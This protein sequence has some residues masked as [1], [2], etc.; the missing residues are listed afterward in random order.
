MAGEVIAVGDGVKGWKTGD[1]V[2]ANFML[3]KLHDEQNAE[4]GATALGGATH[5]VLTEYRTFPAHVRWTSL[6]LKA[7]NCLTA[8]P[9]CCP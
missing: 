1:R 9:H 2:C 4:I 7:T 3:D 6:S 5:G 8:V